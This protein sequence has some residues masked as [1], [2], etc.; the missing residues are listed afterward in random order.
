MVAARTKAK[1]NAPRPVY[2]VFGSDD[3]LRA[4][5]VEMLLGCLLGEDRGNGAL[6]LFEGESAQLADVLDECRTPSL[7]APLRVICVRD[8]DEFVTTHRKSLEA[9]LEK[10]IPSDDPKKAKP[11]LPE[12]RCSLLLVCKAWRKTTRLYKLVERVG[13]NIACEPPKGRAGLATWAVEQARSAHGCRLAPAAAGRL[14]DLVGDDLGMLNMELA[15]LATYVGDRGEI[16]PKDVEALVGWSRVERVF[17]ITDAIA[18]RDVRRALTLWEQVLANDRR[19]SYL[20]VGGLAYGFRRLAEAKRM[21]S[22]GCSVAEAKSR[23]NIWAQTGDLSRQL[24]RFSL[25]QWQDHLVKLLRID[26]AAKTGLGT[27]ESA[28]EKLILE[29]CQ[30]S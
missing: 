28:V 4:Q 12:V 21:T 29:L 26:L 17:G 3:F 5:A 19:A 9:F 20:A 7:L 30:A 6:T 10:L 18:R 2:A 24:D 1:N 13:A 15:K 11:L 16:A 27:V 8:A 22:Q 14:V 23:L 25:L